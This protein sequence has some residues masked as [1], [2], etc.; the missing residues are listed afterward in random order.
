[1]LCKALA[2][3]AMTG[4]MLQHAQAQFGD[5]PGMPGGLGAGGFVGPPFA[6]PPPKCQALLAIRDELQK[7]GEVISAANY[8]KADVKIACRLFRTYIATEAKMIQMLDADGPSCGVPLSINEQVRGSHAKALQIG[9]QV[10]DAAEPQPVFDDPSSS[11]DDP[12]P[13]FKTYMPRPIEKPHPLIIDPMPF[14]MGGTR[15]P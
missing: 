12:Q 11:F 10:C 1:M 7:H 2:A 8:R 3:I 9:K 13:P 5:M 6:A 14:K 4:V 15:Q